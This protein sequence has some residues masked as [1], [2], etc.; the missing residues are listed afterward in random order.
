MNIKETYMKLHK[1][2]TL[3]EAVQQIGRFQ[4]KGRVADFGSA[5]GLSKF[6]PSIRVLE[7]D[8]I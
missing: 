8:G 2:M 4:H 6:F 1:E 3:N 5:R 7:V